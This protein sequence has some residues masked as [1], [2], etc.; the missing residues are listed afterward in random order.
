MG[1]RTDFEDMERRKILPLP[2]R[3]LRHLGHAA[4]KQSLDRL[5]Y[6]GSLYIYA[7]FEHLGYTTQTS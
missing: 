2:G 3:G 4:R 1:R 5:R 7:Y 6:P